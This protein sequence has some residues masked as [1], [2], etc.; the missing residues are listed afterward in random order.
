MCTN[1]Y[2]LNIYIFVRFEYF[3]IMAEEEIR[4]Q[5]DPRWQHGELI[6]SVQKR[7]KFKWCG[8]KMN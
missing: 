4:S 3:N 6:D 8:M 7:V 1:S 5:E 2:V